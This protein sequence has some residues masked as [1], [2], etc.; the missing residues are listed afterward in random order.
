MWRGASPLMFS[1]LFASQLYFLSKSVSTVSSCPFCTAIQSGVWNFS[2]ENS[3][4]T[5]EL[6]LLDDLECYN[7]L[8][9]P[10]TFSRLDGLNRV[11]LRSITRK[12]LT[13][14]WRIEENTGS[15]FNE[16][17]H[18]SLWRR[19]VCLL[20]F[21]RAYLW[22][23]SSVVIISGNVKKI[24]ENKWQLTRRINNNLLLSGF[25]SSVLKPYLYLSWRHS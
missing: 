18:G 3:Q 7:P 5:R 15:I 17:F 9:Y 1:L 16:V 2:S 19:D 25:S 4:K 6:P 24:P 8:H 11:I 22:R 23:R 14:T 21:W 20:G 13:C 12:K 10:I